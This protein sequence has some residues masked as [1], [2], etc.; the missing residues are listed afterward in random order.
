[1]NVLVLLPSPRRRVDRMT[2]VVLRQAVNVMEQNNKERWGG[3]LRGLCPLT[4]RTI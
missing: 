3:L 1:M 2:E 4:R